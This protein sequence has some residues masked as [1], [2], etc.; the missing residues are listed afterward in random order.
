MSAPRLGDLIKAAC[1]ADEAFEAALRTAGYQ[2]RWA[3]NQAQD[4]RP[5]P[6]YVTKVLAD[7]AMHRGFEA[8]RT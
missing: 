6:A 5:M 8:Y 3:W 7:E 1:E 2:T 4:S